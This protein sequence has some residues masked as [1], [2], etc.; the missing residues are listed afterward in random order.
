MN[1]GILDKLLNAF[2][3]T[4]KSDSGSAGNKPS[5]HGDETFIKEFKAFL[6][7]KGYKDISESDITKKLKKHFGLK[8]A[9]IE[10]H[11][12]NVSIEYPKNLLNKSGKAANSSIGK[13]TKLSDINTKANNA[14]GE[15][16][17]NGEVTNPNDIKGGNKNTDAKVKGAAKLKTESSQGQPLSEQVSASELKT[18]DGT[19]ASS[20]SPANSAEVKSTSNG[21]DIK[22]DTNAAKKTPDNSESEQNK[23]GKTT[24][25]TSSNQLAATKSSVSNHNTGSE[26]SSLQKLSGSNTNSETILSDKK[27]GAASQSVNKNSL[28]PGIQAENKNVPSSQSGEISSVSKTDFVPATESNTKKTSGRNKASFTQANNNSGNIKQ[29]VETTRTNTPVSKTSPIPNQQNSSTQIKQ[30]QYLGAEVI[31]KS[32]VSNGADTASFSEK[33]VKLNFEL[34]TAHAKHSESTHVTTN[35]VAKTSPETNGTK[36]QQIKQQQIADQQQ[37][38]QLLESTKNTQKELDFG[39][40]GSK[41]DSEGQSG[42]LKKM[43]KTGLSTNAVNQTEHPINLFARRDLP[44]KLVQMVQQ[45]NFSQRSEGKQ[46]WHKHRILLDEG[47][48]LNVAIRKGDGVIQLQLSS[49]NAE[50]NK[51]IQ[52]HLNDIR[53]HLQQQL[54]MDVELHLQQDGTGQQGRFDE[55]FEEKSNISNDGKK[56]L[57]QQHDSKESAERQPRTRYY[58][59]N[60]NEWTA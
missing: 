2:T 11:G 1:I 34:K 27:A 41:K 30:V 59:F 57:E 33:G 26:N 28:N 12:L 46:V 19:K 43:A 17:K 47:K 18:K 44:A 49:G 23:T 55:K 13:H 36:T 15:K 9:T 6:E 54:G 32:A 37:F 24:R 45:Q 29:G 51:I 31:N 16:I 4:V 5:L 48:S 56:I 39:Q 7:E 38:N 22:P 25:K 10:K 50:M 14:T 52:Q 42:D 35:A 58:G 21:K 40:Q 53:Q 3:N 60:N 8:E 20:L